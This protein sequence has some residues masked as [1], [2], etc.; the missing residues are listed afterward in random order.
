LENTYRNPSTTVDVWVHDWD[1]DL[2]PELW[3]GDIQES[4]GDNLSSPMDFL[5]TLALDTESYLGGSKVEGVVIKNYGQLL[6]LHGTIRHLTTKYV[7]DEFREKASKGHKTPRQSIDE[8]LTSF[9]SR[10]A[11]LAPSVPKVIIWATWSVP[12]FCDT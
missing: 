12:Y 6:E 9:R 7:R 8:Y 11:A 1:I 10:M 3:K 4:L 5:R 2:I